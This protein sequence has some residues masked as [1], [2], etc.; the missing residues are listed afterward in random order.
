MDDRMMTY[1]EIVEQ[2]S[3]SQRKLLENI[4]YIKKLISFVDKVAHDEDIKEARDK[5]YKWTLSV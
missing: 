3:T 1:S 2:L 5:V 4:Q